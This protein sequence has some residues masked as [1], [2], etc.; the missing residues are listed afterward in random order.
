V[1]GW[2]P[3]VTPVDRWHDFSVRI[4]FKVNH[5]IISGVRYL[6]VAKRAGVPG[7]D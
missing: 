7:T 2:K 6:Q 4:A 5:S 3:G 1:R